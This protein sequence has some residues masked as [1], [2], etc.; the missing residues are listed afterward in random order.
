MGKRV[1]FRDP[2]RAGRRHPSHRGCSHRAE[3]ARRSAGP[4]LCERRA[5]AHR[6]RFWRNPCRSRGRRILEHPERDFGRRSSRPMVGRRARRPP[7]AAVDD[8]CTTRR[9]VLGSGGTLVL[10]TLRP[11][12][13]L[14]RANAA[15]TWH[16]P[17]RRYPAGARLDAGHRIRRRHGRAARQDHARITPRRTRGAGPRALASAAVLRHRRRDPPLAVPAA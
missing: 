1:G 16:R 11:R 3:L 15:P 6:I 13:H 10:H 7:R 8:G 12:L 9:G 5:R 14:G 2:Q 4:R 17:G